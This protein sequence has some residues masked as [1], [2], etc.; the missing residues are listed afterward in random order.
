MT[1]LVGGDWRERALE[2][3]K[4]R[5]RPKFQWPNQEAWM[6]LATFLSAIATSA[7]VLIALQ[8]YWTMENALTAPNRNERFDEL[9]E[10]INEAC[11]A[12]RM[13]AYNISAQ[14]L[15]KAGSDE[16]ER[17]EA[18]RNVMRKA[19]DMYKIWVPT[20]QRLFFRDVDYVFQIP[21]TL[22]RTA[23]E[24]PHIDTLR[25][26]N[27]TVRRICYVGP[28]QLIDWFAEGKTFDLA[29]YQ[30]LTGN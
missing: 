16:M 5:P 28:G 7:T 17:M 29:P 15:S 4:Q 22:A 27:P 20:K 12:H 3:I 1:N 13:F 26:L 2:K 19:F 8:Q 14:D 11:L 24:K 21:F 18:S 25:E 23:F 30:A 10:S 9:L 6:V